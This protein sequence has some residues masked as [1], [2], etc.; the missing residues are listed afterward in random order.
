MSTFLCVQIFHRIALF[1]STQCYVCSAYTYCW[2]Y[3]ASPLS[4]NFIYAHDFRFG[5]R[6]NIASGTKHFLF[7]AIEVK[8]TIA[9]FGI[10]SSGWFI[11]RKEVWSRSL[12]TL[13]CVFYLLNEITVCIQY[14]TF[15]CL[16]RLLCHHVLSFWVRFQFEMET[17]FWTLEMVCPAYRV[18]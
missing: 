15:F 17:S 14:K 18:V 6:W 8:C 13:Q 7:V 5:H 16:F 11:R 1:L 9:L 2:M 4:S 3:W 12:F 10:T